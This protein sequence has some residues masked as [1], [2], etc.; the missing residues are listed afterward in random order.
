V[1]Q[2]AQRATF[3]VRIARLPQGVDAR[4]QISGES[5]VIELA[6]GQAH[7][8]HRFSIAH[9]LGHFHLGHRH[10]ENALAEKQAN[11]FAG[12]LLA[13]GQ[14]LTRDLPKFSTAAALASRYDVSREVIFY[15]AKDARLLSRLK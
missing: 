12:A 6:A 1:E 10:G 15:A 7:T 5:R 9:E 11:I 3:K 14:W 8:R 4:L 13:P 2:L